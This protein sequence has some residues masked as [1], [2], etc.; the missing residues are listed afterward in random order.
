MSYHIEKN[1]VQETLVI[2]LYG[3]KLCTEQF[4][5]LF[6]DDKAVKLINRIDY[7]FSELEK[8]SKSLAYR[9]GALEVAMRENDLMI[10]AKDYLKT[11]PGAALVNLGCGLDQTAENCDDGLCRIYNLDLPDVIAVRNALLPEGGRVKNIAADLNELSWFDHIDAEKGV[12][13]LAAGVFYYFKTNE[14]KRLFTAMAERFPDGR[15]VF[16]SANRRAVKLMLKTWVKEAG[17]TSI[18]DYFSVDSI[19]KDL[20]PWMKN[21]EVTSRGYMLGYNDLKDPSVNELFR[22]MA[23]LGDGFMKMRIIKMDFTE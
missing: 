1:S 23:K 5:N 19:E 18:A 22:L 6:R 17:I 8:R 11:H 13:F 3:R 7:D 9:F 21:A 4:P 15:L 14:I 12:C 16:D 2:P 10:E 20:L